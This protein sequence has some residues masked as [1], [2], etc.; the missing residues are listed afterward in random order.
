MV[1]LFATA[2]RRIADYFS[3][4]LTHSS[5]PGVLNVVTVGDMEHLQRHVRRRHEEAATIL[6][7]RRR[8]L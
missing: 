6:H 7:R 3:E 1:S 5:Y 4:I 2:G 8:I